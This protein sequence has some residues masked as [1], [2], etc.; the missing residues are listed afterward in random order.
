LSYASESLLFGVMVW[1]AATEAAARGAL[2]SFRA[3]RCQ[4]WAEARGAVPPG[5]ACARRR[6]TSARTTAGR[7]ARSGLAGIAGLRPTAEPP[8]TIARARAS[9]VRAR[10]NAGSVRSRG[11]GS[12]VRPAGPSPRPCGPWQFAQRSAKIRSASARSAAV[13]T[14]GPHPSGPRRRARTRHPQ[15]GACDA[16]S[17]P[18][19]VRGTAPRG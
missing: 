2:Y 10:R 14:A 7:S 19:R 11:G 15:A 6:S 8:P 16:P 3:G 9:S 5:A 1:S 13:G 4:R 17:A 12:R 18:T